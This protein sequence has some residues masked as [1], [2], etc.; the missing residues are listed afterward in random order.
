MGP[1]TE[2]L[3]PEACH[4]AVPPL[5]QHFREWQQVLVIIWRSIVGGKRRL[6]HQVKGNE[7]ARC[8]WKLCTLPA[9]CPGLSPVLG[10][11][12][13]RPSALGSLPPQRHNG[14]SDPNCPRLILHWTC[15]SEKENSVADHPSLRK[16]S[17]GTPMGKS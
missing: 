13:V 2:G 5:P 1:S 4:S 15:S 10:S 12:C 7:K 16:F 9:G 17:L 8:R 11:S 14:R 6:R 3:G